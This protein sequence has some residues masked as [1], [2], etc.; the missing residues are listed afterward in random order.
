MQHASSLLTTIAVSLALAYLS[1]IGARALRLPP[2]IGYL[3]A[4]VL[5]GPFTPGFVADLPIISQLADIGVALLLFGV[6]I[7]FSLADLAAVW[8][9]AVPG[10]LLQVT[11]SALIAFGAGHVLLGWSPEA[12]LVLAFAL[13]IASTAVATRVLDARGHLQSTAGHIALG[14]LVMQDLVVILALVLLPTAA[15][16]EAQHP[17]ALLNTVGS[18]LLEVSGFVAVVLVVGRKLVPWILAW[19]AR[20]RSRELFRLAVIVVALGVAYTS[21]ELVGV[22]LALGAFFAG[23]VLA[24]SDLSHQAAANRCRS[25]R[26]SPCCSLS[27]SARSLTLPCLC[28]RRSSCLP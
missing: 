19:T 2:L 4:G 1:A 25:N 15:E 14:W 8:R 20:D 3:I 24:K 11:L 28:R 22:S 5:I 13:A 10:A 12:A 17:E 26:C 23:V 9:V 18:K 7:H 6:G 21:A 16:L 27:R